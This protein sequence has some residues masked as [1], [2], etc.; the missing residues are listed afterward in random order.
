MHHP[1]QNL[2]IKNARQ[3]NLA[4]YFWRY[5]VGVV[6]HPTQI[7]YSNPNIPKSRFN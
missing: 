4:F 5:A 6:Q 7:L 1:T 3:K 2:Y